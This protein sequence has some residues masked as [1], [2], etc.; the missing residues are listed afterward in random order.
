MRRVLREVGFGRVYDRW[1][2]RLP[3]EGGRL[4]RVLL[5]LIRS[6]AVGKL[7][8]NVLLHGSS[9]AAIKPRQA[10]GVVYNPVRGVR[11]CPK[12]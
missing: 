5:A 1:D 9:Y 7:I 8:A 2:L 4:Y 3:D 12:T 11:K 6:S 10:A